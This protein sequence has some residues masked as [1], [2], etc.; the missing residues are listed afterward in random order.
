MLAE[1]DAKVK[2]GLRVELHFDLRQ[3]QLAELEVLLEFD[4]SAENMILS[5]SWHMG[6]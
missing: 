5:I 1:I 2:V 6:P 4:R 3:L